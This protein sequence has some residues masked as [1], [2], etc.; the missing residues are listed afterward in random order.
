MKNEVLSF[1]TLI[2]YGSLIS[3]HNWG[4]LFGTFDIFWTSNC[5]LTWSSN[6]HVEENSRD[7]YIDQN[8]FEF[9]PWTSLQKFTAKIEV[10]TTYLAVTNYMELVAS[11]QQ[12]SVSYFSS[13]R[14]VPH[15]CGV[16]WRKFI[17]RTAQ[18]SAASSFSLAGTDDPASF[19]NCFALWKAVSRP[20]RDLMRRTEQLQAAALYAPEQTPYDGRVVFVQRNFQWVRGEYILRMRCCNLYSDEIL[21]H[22]L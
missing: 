1:W 11:R 5:S 9:I 16:Q 21:H 15:F 6:I 20:S 7:V 14:Y 12:F 18:R 8:N 13:R 2:Y 3:K 4:A 22:Y 17:V 19:R 10:S